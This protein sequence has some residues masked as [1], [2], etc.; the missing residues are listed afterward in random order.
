MLLLSPAALSSLL[1]PSFL[2]VA[3][4]GDD[5]E[6]DDDDDGDPVADPSFSSLP[7][8]GGR[9]EVGGGAQKVVIKSRISSASSTRSARP[10]AVIAAEKCLWDEKRQ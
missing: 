10:H 6:D 7:F 5:D 1:L 9:W 3:D 2:I 8:I 4:D